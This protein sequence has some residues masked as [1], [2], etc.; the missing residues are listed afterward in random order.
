MDMTQTAQD[1]AVVCVI[2]RHVLRWP[3]LKHIAV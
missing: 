1:D 2:P 3:S